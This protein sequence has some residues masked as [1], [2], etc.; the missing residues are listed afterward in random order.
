[1]Y[2]YPMLGY[3]WQRIYPFREA[4]S[5]GESSCGALWPTGCLRACREIPET[6]KVLLR[7]MLLGVNFPIRGM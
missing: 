4:R 1:M 3:S 2:Q 7:S 5:V 6:H